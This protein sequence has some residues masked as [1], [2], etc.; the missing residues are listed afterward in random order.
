MVLT[1]RYMLTRV[2]AQLQWHPPQRHHLGTLHRDTHQVS[3]Q[4]FR[5]PPPSAA[6]MASCTPAAATTKTADYSCCYYQG[7]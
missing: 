5:P 6:L 2:M 1:R 3:V 4:I 7:C